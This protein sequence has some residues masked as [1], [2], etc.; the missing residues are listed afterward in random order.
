MSVIRKIGKKLKE[1]RKHKN[2]FLLIEFSK[3]LSGSEKQGKI[4]M[5]GK[6]ADGFIEKMIKVGFE[7][8]VFEFNYTKDGIRY[9]MKIGRFYDEVA[10]EKLNK[11]ISDSVMPFIKLIKSK[12]DETG[13]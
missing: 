7:T 8:K 6:T 9:S 11:D 4:L 3:A 1:A 13:N 2:D 12:L 10:N 5:R